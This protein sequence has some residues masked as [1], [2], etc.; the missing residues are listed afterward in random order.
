M[1]RFTLSPS[2]SVRCATAIAVAILFL[3]G[4]AISARQKKKAHARRPT[5]HRRVVHHRRYK[6]RP[7]YARV[8]LQP[9]RVREIQQALVKAGTLHEEPNGKWDDATREAMRQYQQENGFAPTGLPEAKP[10]MKLGLGPHPLPPGLS[11]PPAGNL[12]S[13]GDAE[14]STASGPPTDGQHPSSNQ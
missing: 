8:H 14:A 12:E 7:G 10:L 11:S 1:K 3:P 6:R 5:V 4:V 2:L 13:P 9:E